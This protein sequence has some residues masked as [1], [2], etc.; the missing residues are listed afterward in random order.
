LLQAK[1]IPCVVASPE[2]RNDWQWLGS[3][4]VAPVA[5]SGAHFGAASPSSDV[6]NS[7]GRHGCLVLHDIPT[8]RR[9]TQ[10]PLSHMALTPAQPICAEHGSLRPGSAWQVPPEQTRLP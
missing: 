7:P 3:A 10:R 5:P 8:S 1:H 4:Q 2:Q 9:K 6:Q